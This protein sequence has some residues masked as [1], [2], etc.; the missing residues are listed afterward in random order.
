M[1]DDVK[2]AEKSEFKWVGQRNPRPDGVDK[3]TGRAKFGAD[4]YMAGTLF[5][6]VVR[7]PHAHAVLKSIDTSE[8]EALPGVKAIVTRDDFK[9][10]PGLTPPYGP[11]IN[12]PYDIVRNILAREKVL[13]DGHPVAAVAATSDAIA[14]KAA[15]LINVEYEVLPHVIHPYEAAQPGAPLLHEYITHGVEPA[16][17]EPSNVFRVMKGERGD[18]EKG[19]NAADV[20]IAREFDTAPV[21]QGYIEPQ[22]CIANTSEDGGVELWTTTQ[23]HFIARGTCAMLLGIDINKIRVTA[24]E[25][26]GGFGGK[27]NVY[28]EPLAIKLSMKS[29]RPV[30]MV[31]SRDEV[32]RATGPTA[33]AHVKVKIGAKKDGTITAI[34]AD[35]WYQAGAFKGAP[36]PAAVNCAA[37]PYTCENLQLIGYDVSVNRP[38]VAAYR[39]PGVPMANLAVETVID[40]ICKQIGMDPIDMRLKN[41]ANEGDKLVNGLTLGP[42]GLVEILERAKNHPQYKNKENLAPNQGLGFAAGCWMHNGG[43]SCATINVQDDGSIN[44]MEGSP[45]IGGS[46]ASMCAMVAEELGVDYNTVRPIIGDTSAIGFHALTAGSRVT[47]GT[48]MAC[49]EAARDAIRVLCE[50]AAKMWDVSVDEVVWEDGEARPASSN[51]GDFEPLTLKEIAAKAP[52]TGGPIAGHHE[53]NAGAGGPAFGAQMVTL[54]VDLE[55]GYTKVLGHT[56]FQDVGRAISPDYVEGQMQGGASQGVGWA[57]NEEYIYDDSGILENPGFL[58]Y[59]VPVAS[60]MTMI[61]CEM[62]EVPHPRHPYGVRGVGETPIV[63]PQ[64]AVLNAVENATGKKFDSLPVSPPKILK[65]LDEGT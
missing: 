15:K 29:H 51:V 8:A 44:L 14:K 42:V 22:A 12:D 18:V 47:F 50:R 49:V 6:R 11:I 17:T 9:D 58:D 65:A 45:D 53:L 34:K 1:P 63:T 3:V 62:I 24:S 56:V 28:L 2:V 61:N 38:K 52:M 48:G 5:G 21:H 37:A 59:R 19:L 60:D 57:L 32:F 31:M 40:D 25:I 4:M 36:L 26:G 10:Q 55:T 43:I 39:A 64:A 13:Y 16:P 23:G 54:E 46:R 30:K 7:S 35:M 41:A 20:V 27:N 33:G